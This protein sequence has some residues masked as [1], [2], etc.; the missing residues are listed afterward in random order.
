MRRQPSFLAWPVLLLVA[1]LV[2]EV[3][4]VQSAREDVR[5]ALAA[6]ST[7]YSR[8][9][10]DRGEFR[11]LVLRLEQDVG[12]SVAAALAAVIAFFRFRS[13]WAML[14]RRDRKDAG[15]CPHCTYNLKGNVSGCCPECGAVVAGLA[16][17]NQ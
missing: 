13:D 8:G 2:V 14:T 10:S 5:L 1:S 9:Y 12:L 11:S 16:E 15:L 7:V 17:L 4:A 3:M 6:R